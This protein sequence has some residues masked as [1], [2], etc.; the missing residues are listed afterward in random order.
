MITPQDEQFLRRAMRLAM[1][2]RGYTEP[3]PSVGCVLVKNGETIGEGWTQP[4][5]GA[6]AEP[7]AMADCKAKGNDPAGA[8]AYVTL[9]PCCH[10]NK[11]TPPCAPRLIEAKVARVVIGCLDP[12]PDV[13]GNGVTMLR[14]AGIEVEV[15]ADGSHFEQ[16][17]APFILHQQHRRPYITMK[18]AESSNGKVAGPGGVRLRISNDTSTRFVHLL[19]A[20][21]DALMVGVNT[22]INDDPLLNV[23]VQDDYSR[24]DDIFIVD[25][26][27]RTPPHAKLFEHAGW[28]TICFSPGTGRSDEGRYDRLSALTNRF[29]TTALVVDDT[30]AQDDRVDLRVLFSQELWERKTH[31]LVEAGPTLGRSFFETGLCDRLFVIRSQMSVADDSAPVA[32][33]IPNTFVATATLDLAGDTLTEYLNTASPAFFAAVPSADFVLAQ[34][35]A[36]SVA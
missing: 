28:V 18:W 22:I 8:T 19:R 29:Q 23:R 13:D 20:R 5:G 4:F 35:S 36:S 7:T 30:E 24:L 34:E 12:N 26:K 25:S 11:K 32:R 15:L 17:I 14:A 6:H 33:P 31:L 3:N 2:G 9:E 1:N 21:S 27:V 16:L 10:T